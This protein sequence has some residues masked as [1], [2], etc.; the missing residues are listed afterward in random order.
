MPLTYYW[1]TSHVLV[2]T[3]CRVALAREE[4]VLERQL[5]GWNTE[6]ESSLGNLKRC[7]EWFLYWISDNNVH[8]TNDTMIQIAQN[9]LVAIWMWW[10]V[11]YIRAKIRPKFLLA[12]MSKWHLKNPQ[13]SKKTPKHS[14][15]IIFHQLSHTLKR[16]RHPRFKY[17][18][19]RH[20]VGVG[21]FCECQFVDG[22]WRIRFNFE[23]PLDENSIYEDGSTKKVR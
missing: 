19:K 4:T 18:F 17:H 1:M 23:R 22:G 16:P 2:Y 3:W 14:N 13:T 15:S 5:T 10:T 6:S 21:G 9:R 11:R 7:I 12:L 8:N 20:R